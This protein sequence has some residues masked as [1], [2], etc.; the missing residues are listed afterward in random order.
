M[1]PVIQQLGL[2]IK[3]LPNAQQTF[4]KILKWG[5]IFLSFFF[6]SLIS[7]SSRRV[8]IITRGVT[9]SLNQLKQMRVGKA[10]LSSAAVGAAVQPVG[11]PNGAG[12]GRPGPRAGPCAGHGLLPRRAA[13]V[14][15]HLCAGFCST[16]VIPGQFC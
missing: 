1:T 4:K 3:G 11:N 6:F 7:N 14:A 8:S 16:L 13:E 10:W 9:V 12:G 2:I 5:W 15:W